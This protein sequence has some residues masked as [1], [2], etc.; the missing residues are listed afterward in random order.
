MAA[1]AARDLPCGVGG[2]RRDPL[3]GLPVSYVLAVAEG[4]LIGGAVLGAC[5]VFVRIY[6]GEWWIP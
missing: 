4:L 5:V 6:D 3:A 1:R 2:C